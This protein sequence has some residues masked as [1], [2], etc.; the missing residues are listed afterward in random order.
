MLR[1]SAKAEG[2]A[3]NVQAVSNA[4][5]DPLIPGGR[6]L[7]AFVDAVTLVDFEELAIA[8]GDLIAELGLPGASRA[9]S[10]CAAFE[11]TNR[12][13]DAF[14]VKVNKRYLDIGDAIGVR[15]PDHLL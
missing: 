8:R 10:V 1:E 12:I 13:L 14:G 5:L 6:E 7:I 4:V 3:V 9:A 11:G 15:V 2:R